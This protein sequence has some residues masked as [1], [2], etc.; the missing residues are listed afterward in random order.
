MNVIKP[1][2]AIVIATLTV[3]CGGP[4]SDLNTTD[5]AVLAAGGSFD[6]SADGT[7]FNIERDTRLCPAPVCGGYWVDSLNQKKVECA[8][9]SVSAR[10]YVAEIAFSRLGFSSSQINAIEQD[11]SE[12]G[13]VL[14]GNLT[15]RY[16]RQHGA[17]GV[18]QPNA[19]WRAAASI[20]PQGEFLR[21]EHRG[22]KDYSQPCNEVRAHSANNRTSTNAQ[23][24]LFGQRPE[25]ITGV[26]HE[27]FAAGQDAI[28][29]NKLLVAG[30]FGPG[31]FYTNAV[32]ASQFYLPCTSRECVRGGTPIVD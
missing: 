27:E 3:A 11:I 26:T 21:I 20:A 4:D 18:L 29:A 30:S 15:R 32:I 28:R 8:D 19:A 6:A 9:G 22:C 10:C 2:A 14:Q 16:D 23:W 13:V 7:Y 25:Y 17:V 5:D 1:L 12:D 31:L 24:V